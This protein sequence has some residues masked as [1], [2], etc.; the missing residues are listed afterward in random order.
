MK[1]IDSDTMQDF[2]NWLSDREQDIA[3]GSEDFG[4][5]RAIFYSLFDRNA[6]EKVEHDPC[7]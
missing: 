7:W 4:E 5:L 3:D 2:L 6:G 1:D